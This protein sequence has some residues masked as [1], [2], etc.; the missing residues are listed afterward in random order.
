MYWTL[1]VST[2][3]WGMS[4]EHGL[5]LQQAHMLS[6]KQNKKQ[7]Y[8]LFEKFHNNSSYNI[9]YVSKIPDKIM[10]VIQ[11]NYVNLQNSNFNA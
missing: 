3:Q 11:V 7:A 5:G 1:T 10:D 6:S 8:I 2:L 9:I 4:D